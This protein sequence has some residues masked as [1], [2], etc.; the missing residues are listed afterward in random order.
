MCVV[1]GVFGAL[2]AMLLP[3]VPAVSAQTAQRDCSMVTGNL[4]GDCGFELPSLDT[5]SN[6]IIAANTR[7]PDATN[8]PW[9]AGSCGAEIDNTASHGEWNPNNGFQS[10][11]VNPDGPNAPLSQEIHTD[12]GHVY[13]VSFALA[14]N[15]IAGGIFGACQNS[16]GLKA[17]TVSFGAFSKDLTFP[18][19][20]D[21][22]KMNWTATPLGTTLTPSAGD[23]PTLTFIGT[24]P[25]PCGAT[26]DDVIVT[27]STPQV[28]KAFSPTTIVQGDTA[29]LIF[30][31]ANTGD[32]AAKT[33]S[34]TDTLPSG[35]SVA[36]PNGVSAGTD[37]AAV[38][39]AIARG[40]SA[41]W[42]RANLT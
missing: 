14:G 10:A 36:S 41:I 17:L 21:P 4:V 9:F 39:D 16:P 3:D 25:G 6:K 38:D 27:D 7:F 42:I 26:I 19:T 34:F 18:S 33:W 1:I 8:G 13:A 35:M 29:T 37:M 20:G 31:I 15:P 28:T 2:A 32:M 22:N 11:D 12:P 30:T 5:A 24:S 23:T 40:C